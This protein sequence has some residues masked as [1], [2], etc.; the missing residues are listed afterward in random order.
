MKKRVVTFHS[1]LCF[2]ERIAEAIKTAELIDGM[3]RI[4]LKQMIVQDFKVVLVWTEPSPADKLEDTQPGP[5]S[6]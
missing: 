2:A 5:T 4:W 3:Q 1:F 6:K